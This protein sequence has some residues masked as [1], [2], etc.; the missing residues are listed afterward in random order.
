MNSYFSHDSNARNDQKILQL[1]IQHHAAGYGVYFMIL[2]RLREEKDYMSIK[3]YNSI[4]FDLHED[5][6]LIKN[7]VEDF[8]LFVFTEDGEYF[9]SESFNDRM[10]LKDEKSRKRSNAGKKG[11]AKRWNDNANQETSSN[12]GNAITKPRK[13]GN[14]MAKPS[15]NIASK[16]KESKGKERKVNQTKEPKTTETTKDIYINAREE[17]FNKIETEFGRPLSPIELETISIWIDEDHFS[18]EI[19]ICALQ[20]AVL[21]QVWNLKYMNTILQNWSKQHITNKQEYAAMKQQRAN[22]K[23]PVEPVAAKKTLPKIPIYKIS[24]QEL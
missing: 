14:A 21:N 6:G 23:A 3:D 8:G 19:I 20:E 22:Q 5:A 16:V 1:R 15:E 4:A 18:Y 13:N 24:E 2:E 9:Y 7:V 12:D 17:I 10:A 11:A